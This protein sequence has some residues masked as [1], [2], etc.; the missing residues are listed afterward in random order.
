MQL[1]Y[2]ALFAGCIVA[3]DQF[4]KILT[5]ANIALYQDVEFIPGFLADLCTK[6]RRG[7]FLF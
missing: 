4:T 2:M 1:F 7:F 3:A 5:V 6:Y